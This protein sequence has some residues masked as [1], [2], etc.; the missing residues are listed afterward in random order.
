MTN[1]IYTGIGSRE[2]PNN[3]L[4]MMSDIAFRLGEL[5]Y[6]LRSGHAP[7]ADYAFESGLSYNHK[8]EI[9]LPVANWG[10]NGVPKAPSALG[11]ICNIPQDAYRIA[12]MHHPNW[13]NLNSFVQK[14]MARNVQQVLGEN[15]KVPTKVVLFWCPLDSNN[16]PKGGTAQALKV[17]KSNNIPYILVEDTNTVDYYVQKVIE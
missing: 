3:I 10:Y 1:T 17:A 11:Y 8:R 9:Y 14:L 6:T 7:G 16:N 12:M 4:A 13:Y 2:T 5:D 15:L